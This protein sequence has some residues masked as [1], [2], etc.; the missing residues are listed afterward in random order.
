MA[1]AAAT[2]ASEAAEVP[3]SVANASSETASVLSTATLN[4]AAAP[5]DAAAV[6]AEK[7]VVPRTG[8]VWRS[9]RRFCRED[10]D[11]CRRYLCHFLYTLK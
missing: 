3:H 9:D 1:A 11:F 2:S 8:P 10:N 4:D 6:A 7:P 5:V